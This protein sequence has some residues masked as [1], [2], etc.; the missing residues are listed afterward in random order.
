MLLRVRN[1]RLLSCFWVSLSYLC[2][3]V[4]DTFEIGKDILG[5]PTINVESVD[6]AVIEGSPV[7]ST[8]RPR[9]VGEASGSKQT[10]ALTTTTTTGA[11]GQRVSFA[12]APHEEGEESHR[13][14][15]EQAALILPTTSTEAA[16]LTPSPASDSHP[17]QDPDSTPSSPPTPTGNSK[18]NL[19]PPPITERSGSATS[20]TH[21]ERDAP[22]A[23]LHP[24]P[25]QQR[26]SLSSLRPVFNRGSKGKGKGR[27]TSSHSGP[28]AHT[29]S[30]QSDVQE[31]PPA[32]PAEVLTRV[33]TEEP[34]TSAG[35]AAILQQD[36]QPATQD[37]DVVMRDRMLV[38]ILYSKQDGFARY[39]DES[40]F[41]EI[42]D[43][44]QEEWGEFIAVW[45]RGRIE[46]YEDYVSVNSIPNLFMF[47][48]HSIDH[49]SERMVLE[50][51]A[52]RVRYP[53]PPWVHEDF[54]ILADRHV[55]LPAMSANARVR[56]GGSEVVQQPEDGDEP[57]LA[58]DEEQVTGGRLDVEAVVCRWQLG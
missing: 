18:T 31:P 48:I 9:L 46:L 8:R 55:D 12:T 19:I 35:A 41:A 34:S 26:T 27:P 14:A 21:S 20:E 10:G 3:R 32:P 47:T 39:M 50:A 7:A 52:P 45:R 15:Q 44:K 33:A 6:T 1:G 53:P 40:Q 37:T 29:S 30:Y 49:R 54:D 13:P 58:T 36:L 16:T 4:G 25:Q 5:L 24:P 42:T 38:R 51:Q 57:V 43:V 28:P 22:H 23:E 17:P 11:T 56:I 2:N